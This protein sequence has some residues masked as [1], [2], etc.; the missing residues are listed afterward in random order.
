MKTQ[1]S[2]RA[3]KKCFE[4]VSFRQLVDV[5]GYVDFSTCNGHSP[6]KPEK[7]V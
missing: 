4:E 5:R 7:S 3:D 2:C 1:V 6:T